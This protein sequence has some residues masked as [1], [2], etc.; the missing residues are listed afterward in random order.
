VA[1]KPEF[2]DMISEATRQSRR[3]QLPR[4][5]DLPP[6]KETSRLGH[7]TDRLEAWRM[8]TFTPW[9]LKSWKFKNW[10]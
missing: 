10:D 8:E 3:R 9:K 5:I 7:R 4:I 2:V 6:V 1:D